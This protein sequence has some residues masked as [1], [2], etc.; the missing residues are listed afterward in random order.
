[1]PLDAVAHALKIIRP[2]DAAEGCEMHQDLAVDAQDIEKADI[3]L[4]NCAALLFAQR[5]G[6]TAVLR[7]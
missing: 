1:M 3:R 4:Q 7:R 5:K 6:C 2:F